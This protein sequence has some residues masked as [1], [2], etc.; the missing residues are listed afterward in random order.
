[1]GFL[2]KLFKKQSK[3]EKIRI[4][5]AEKKKLEMEEKFKKACEESYKN[6]LSQK[7][8]T[9]KIGLIEYANE[10]DKKVT[11]VYTENGPIS[12]TNIDKTYHKNNMCFRERYSIY[13]GFIDN[14]TEGVEK[15][16]YFRI[17][18]NKHVLSNPVIR[19]TFIIQDYMGAYRNENGEYIAFDEKIDSNF[20]VG[21]YGKIISIFESEIKKA[22]EN[23]IETENE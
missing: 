1:M 9:S 7:E 19:E 17:I 2:D 21:Q 5:E 15:S 6:F 20:H 8:D 18:Y 11:T 4:K 12:K 10:K 13:E 22:K 16:G 14:N 23:E 3:E